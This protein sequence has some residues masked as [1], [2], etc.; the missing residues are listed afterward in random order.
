MTKYK[1][2]NWLRTDKYHLQITTAVGQKVKASQQQPKILKKINVFLENQTENRAV[3]TY[4]TKKYR[5]FLVKKIEDYNL[6][7][8][9]SRKTTKNY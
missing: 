6:F 5:E 2:G 7:E 4:C 9:Y 8:K 3:S 1:N